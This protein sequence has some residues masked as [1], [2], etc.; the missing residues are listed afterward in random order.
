MNRFEL[1]SLCRSSSMEETVLL[2]QQLL[3]TCISS[4]MGRTMWSF[5]CLQYPVIRYSHYAGLVQATTC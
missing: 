1:D 3:T 5:H 2:S 4:R